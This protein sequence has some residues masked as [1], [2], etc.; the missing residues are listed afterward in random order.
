M[1]RLKTAA[2]WRLLPVSGVVL[3]VGLALR[4]ALAAP[5]LSPVDAQLPPR[6]ADGDFWQLV[7]D[8][9]EPNGTFRF[10][11]NLTSNELGFQEVIPEL[12]SRTRTDGVYLGVGPEQNFTYIGAVRPSLA[13][14]L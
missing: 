4:L 10:S 5:H 6:L 13:I 8:W 12:I 9:S 14:I 2:T 11:D 1:Q 7:G 3:A